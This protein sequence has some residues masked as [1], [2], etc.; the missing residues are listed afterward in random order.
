MQETDR[1]PD[2]PVLVRPSRVERRVNNVLERT[3]SVLTS[4]VGVFLV[5]FVGVAL[6]GVIEQIWEP[7]VRQH[8]FTRAALRGVDAAFVAI[9]LLELVH[10]TVSQGP[11]T[12]QLQHFLVIGVTAGVRRGLDIAAGVREA[13]PREIII[14]LVLNSVA[15]LVLVLAW[16]LVRH[17]LHTE[18][19]SAAAP[20]DHSR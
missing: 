20:S 11:L 1:I 9:I 18:R 14:D 13:T 4:V 19:P 17:R 3:A 6:F 15:V 7:L 2:E 5:L 10:T 12:R 8:D 16:V